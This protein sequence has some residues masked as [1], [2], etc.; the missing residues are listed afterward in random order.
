MNNTFDFQEA[1]SCIKADM[2]VCLNIDGKERNYFLNDIYEKIIQRRGEKINGKLLY[3]LQRKG[4]KLY[5]GN[6]Q[7]YK[8]EEGDNYKKRRLSRKGADTAFTKPFGKA[9]AKNQYCNSKSFKLVH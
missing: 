9:I 8:R 1:L 2:P 5:K 7:H 4:E 6:K 3:L